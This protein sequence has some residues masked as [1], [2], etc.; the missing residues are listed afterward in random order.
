MPENL[1]KIQIEKI[2]FEFG[3]E[4]VFSDLMEVNL[5]GLGKEGAGAWRWTQAECMG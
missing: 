3:Y 5:R 2:I 1:H 4:E